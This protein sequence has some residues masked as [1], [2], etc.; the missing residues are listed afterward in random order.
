MS[1]GNSA[2]SVEDPYKLK[3]RVESADIILTGKMLYIGCFDEDFVEIKPDGPCVLPYKKTKLRY[4]L[5]TDKI[6][7][8]KN[9]FLK[10]H[11]L[12][13]K[14]FY[15]IP[16]TTEMKAEIEDGQQKIFFFKTRDLEPDIIDSINYVPATEREKI[17][18]FL[19]KKSSPQTF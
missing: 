10:E 2:P 4:S 19:P 15:Y 8:G 9:T 7:K 1:W 16:V 17:K 12:L 6:L 5:R 18:Q 14:V 11:Q 3:Q 13:Q